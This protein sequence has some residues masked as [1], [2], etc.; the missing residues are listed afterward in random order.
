MNKNLVHISDLIFYKKTSKDIL[1]FLEKNKIENLEFFIE[2]L[3]EE[4]TK[5]MIEI[6]ENHELKSVSFHGPFRK[7][8]LADMTKDSWERTLYS[9]EESFKLSKKYNPS[10]MVLHSNEGI[11]SQKIDEELKNK[12][13]EKIDLLVKLGNK[14][15]I[16]IVIENVGIGRN[17]VF[18]QKEYESMIL[19]NNYKCLIDIG[20][21]FLNKW[22][23]DELIKNLK[24]NILGYHFHN[25][26]GL[27]DEHKPIFEGKFNYLSIIE[28][29]KMYTPTANIVLEYDFNENPEILLNDYNKLK[30][31]FN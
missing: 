20:H 3:D 1:E 11:P 12:I 4:Y 2:P 6:L 19:K 16:N 26:N 29:I 8:N 30:E 27:Y 28:L 5:K 21:A 22:D 24:D 31:L 15:D 9:Y 25:N 10:F 17:M 13:S 7:C 23:I 18:S 14:Y